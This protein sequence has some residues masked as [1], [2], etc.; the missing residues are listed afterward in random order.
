MEDGVNNLELKA[1][2][3]AYKEGIGHKSDHN[4]EVKS[5]QYRI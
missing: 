3:L 2:I 5:D 4:W 1:G